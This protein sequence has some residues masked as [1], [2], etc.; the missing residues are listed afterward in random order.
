M[1]QILRTAF[2]DNKHFLEIEH[3]LSLSAEDVAELTSIA[4]AQDVRTLRM[5]SPRPKCMVNDKDIL[6]VLRGINFN[7]GSQPDD[8]VSVRIWMDDTTFIASERRPVKS[9]DAAA[10]RIDKMHTTPDLLLAII[11][12][13]QL[14]IE[15]HINE[16]DEQVDS[17]EDEALG[18]PNKKRRLEIMEFRRS[19]IS[20]RRYLLPQRETLL[21]LSRAKVDFFTEDQQQ[22]FLDQYYRAARICDALDA[23]RERL[24]L[25]QEEITAVISDRMNQNMYVLS[26][27]SL[28][29]LPLGFLTGLFGI[30][31]GGMPMVADGGSSLEPMGFW[32]VVGLCIVCAIGIGIVMRIKNWI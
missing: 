26:I 2:G 20:L 21:T 4:G 13:L 1:T 17:A 11:E 24:S 29:F 15:A 32:I 31:V 28:V 19:I 16:L 14:R 8:M 5:A 18:D 25:I 3:C 23:L 7:E 27:I 6:I 9:V 30:N 12:E 10:S 22:S